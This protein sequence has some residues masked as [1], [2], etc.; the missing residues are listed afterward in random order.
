MG[1]ERGVGVFGAISDSGQNT[2]WESKKV[3]LKAYS[4]DSH[5][6]IYNLIFKEFDE[7]NVNE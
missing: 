2:S 6:T 7:E 4:D 3:I 5:N 1:E